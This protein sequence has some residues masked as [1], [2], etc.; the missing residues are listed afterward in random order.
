MH[1]WR[2]IG[3]SCLVSSL[4]VLGCTNGAKPIAQATDDE[5][6]EISARE[7]VVDEATDDAVLEASEPVAEIADATDDT[8]LEVA[9]PKETVAQDLVGTWKIQFDFES[10]EG[11]GEAMAGTEG[12]EGMGFLAS[13]MEMIKG[14]SE[15]YVLNSDGSFVKTTTMSGEGMM[16]G[17]ETVAAGKWSSNDDQI[18]FYI[19][20]MT[21]SM[22]GE[23]PMVQDFAGATNMP[24]M[25]MKLAKDRKTFTMVTMPGMGGAG[26]DP[27]L[28]MYYEKQVE[29][30]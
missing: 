5:G 3:A 16:D 4:L 25:A 14:M 30:D 28:G 9:D 22:P 20:K 13:M 23:D 21:I 12:M 24:P 18:N 15:T 8:P 19:T 10:M 1:S 27:T 29:K 7:D 26:M 6:P 17:M 11:L 2:I